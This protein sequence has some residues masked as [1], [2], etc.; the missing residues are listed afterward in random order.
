MVGVQFPLIGECTEQLLIPYRP[1]DEKL[2]VP[3]IGRPPIRLGGVLKKSV[4]DLEFKKVR[5]KMLDQEK[6]IFYHLIWYSRLYNEAAGR[7]PEVTEQELKKFS[8]AVE[9][10][11]LA[12]VMTNLDG[13]IEYTN[14]KFSEVTGYDRNEAHSQNPNVLKS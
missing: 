2:E 11:P 6:P 12:I 8:H 13:T 9:Q 14:P 5:V 4:F 1:T 10:S 3:R 7:E